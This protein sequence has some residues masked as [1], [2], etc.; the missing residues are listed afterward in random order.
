VPATVVAARRPARIGGTL[1]TSGRR[2]GCG[3][4]LR[5]SGCWLRGKCRTRVRACLRLR[6]AW[7][8]D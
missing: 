1:R 2:S 3:S 4:G 5:A 8:P 7:S 6:A